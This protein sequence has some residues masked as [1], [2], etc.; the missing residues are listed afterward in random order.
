MIKKLKLNLFFETSAKNGSNVDIAFNEAAKMIFLN[1]IKDKVA[2]ANLAYETSPEDDDTQT[3][4][5]K[6]I[7]SASNS[8]K[9]KR[10]TTLVTNKRTPVFKPESQKFCCI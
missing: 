5:T 6:G 10:K 9:S 4:G 3:E 8:P 1:C 7:K 2:E